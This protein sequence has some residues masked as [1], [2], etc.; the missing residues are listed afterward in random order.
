[1]IIPQIRSVVINLLII[2]IGGPLAGAYFA[3]QTGEVPDWHHLWAILQHGGLASS[4]MAIGWLLMRSPYAGKI[5]EL[6]STTTAPS[7]AVQTTAVKI[8]E[9]APSEPKATK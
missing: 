1:M 9:P 8:T 3:W 2:L 4:M 7:G 5:T 6:L